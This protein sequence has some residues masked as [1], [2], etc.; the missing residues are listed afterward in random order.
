MRSF[1]TLNSLQK[2]FVVNILDYI[3]D[4]DAQV[5]ESANV[6]AALDS[7]ADYGGSLYIP[8]GVEA[9][10]ASPITLPANCDIIGDTRATHLAFASNEVSGLVLGA[11]ATLIMEIS[12]SVTNIRIL[13]KSFR[14]TTG[15]ADPEPFFSGTGITINSTDVTVDGCSVYGF[16]TG[17]TSSGPTGRTYLN[18]MKMDNTSCIILDN[19]EDTSRL[20]NIQCWPFAG[21]FTDTDK[22]RAGTAIRLQNNADWTRVTNCF[23]WGYNIGFHLDDSR[24]NVQLIGCGSDYPFLSV[25]STGVLIDGDS[26]TTLIDGFQSELTS[27]GINTNITP[28][29]DNVGSTTIVNCHFGRFSDGVVITAG[30]AIIKNCVFTGQRDLNEHPLGLNR[31][32]YLPTDTEYVNASDN[33]Y[34]NMTALVPFASKALE[35]AGAPAA[36]LRLLDRNLFNNVTDQ[37]DAT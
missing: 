30:D 12:S 20:E 33:I 7:L 3:K 24:S 2:D 5:D 1:R 10:C 22:T 25:V 8:T 17:I 27:T 14:D 16:I 21:G 37:G 4:T 18:D 31:G 26:G 36:G 29:P 34:E 15:V 19:S 11:S 32:I 35:Q 23:T 9:Y 13:S 28:S 6:Q